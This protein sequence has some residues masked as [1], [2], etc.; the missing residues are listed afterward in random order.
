M[1]QDSCKAK[2][3][4]QDCGRQASTRSKCKA[5]ITR[6]AKTQSARLMTGDVRGGNKSNNGFFS[7][8]KQ[9]GRP[10]CSTWSTGIKNS[11]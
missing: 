1:M 4:L 9:K 7:Y 5:P 3:G 10:T 8:A 11:H 6:S 2:E